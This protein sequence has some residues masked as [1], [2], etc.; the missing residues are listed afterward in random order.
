MSQDVGHIRVED[1]PDP[2]PVRRDEPA[3]GGPQ[4]AGNRAQPLLGPRGQLANHVG[5]LVAEDSPEAVAYLLGRRTSA[6]FTPSGGNH[7]LGQGN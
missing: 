2:R 5:G 7:T 6:A 1:G 3:V 4:F